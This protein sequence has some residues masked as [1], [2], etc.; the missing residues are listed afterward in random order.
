MYEQAFGR[1]QQGTPRKS[2]LS[3]RQRHEGDAALWSWLRQGA[4]MNPDQFVTTKHCGTWST[5]SGLLR[6]SSRVVVMGNTCSK[7][8]ELP[9]SCASMK[10]RQC[11]RIAELRQ[12]L[13]RAGYQSLDKQASALGL[14]RSTTWA[15]LQANHKSSGLSGSVIKR[16][17]RSRDLPPAA[18]Q[19]IEEYVAEKLAGTYGHGRKPLRI[20]RAQSTFRTVLR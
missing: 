2:R 3:C 11:A 9:N 12:V 6:A 8:I 17:L 5:S 18:R 13:L 1:R 4:R 20:F 15:V 10:A 19:W 14:S 7:R 16:M